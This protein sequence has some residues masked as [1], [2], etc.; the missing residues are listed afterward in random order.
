M[1][2]NKSLR[3]L[4][5]RG[6]LASKEKTLKP[7]RANIGLEVAYRKKLQAMIEQVHRSALWHIRAAY[8]K[9][10][11]RIAQ[12]ATP[13]DFM[14]KLIQRLKD[15]WLTQIDETAPKLAAYFDQAVSDRTDAA[16]KKILRDGGF[17]VKFQV[18]PAMR[19][20]R[21]ASIAENV[22]LIRSL[23]S[24]YFEEI[25]GIVSRGYANG[26]DLKRVTDELQ[27]RYNVTRNRAKFIASDQASKLNSQLSRARHQE[28]GIRTAIWTHSGGGK[29]PRHT[30]LHVM[31]GKEFDLADG[32]FDPD[33]R[34][35]K[36]IHCGELIRCRCVARPIVPGFS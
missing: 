1:P 31:N 3:P 23:P 32:L 12:D 29:E 22:S 7:I 17:S 9:N 15:R 11:P 16:L 27:A 35:N 34:V 6:P 19:D 25:E 4:K 20:V 30:H 5:K 8:R 24:R 28:I 2:K 21:A 10:P 33:P 18:T 14:R 36:K 26:Y 13:F